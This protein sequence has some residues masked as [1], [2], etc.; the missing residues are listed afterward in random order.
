M[1][2]PHVITLWH[3]LERITA[4]W[5]HAR[6]LARYPL[7]DMLL[8]RRTALLAQIARRQCGEGAR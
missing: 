1:I 7:A 6:A 2:Y 5:E 8:A 3:E 4:A